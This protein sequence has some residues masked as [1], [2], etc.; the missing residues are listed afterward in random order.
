MREHREASSLCFI[1][2]TFNEILKSYYKDQSRC[3]LIQIGIMGK[4]NFVRGKISV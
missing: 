1:R 2:G 3:N 4:M